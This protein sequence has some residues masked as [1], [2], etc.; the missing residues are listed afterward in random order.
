MR[1]VC[2]KCGAH[3]ELKALVNLDQFTDDDLLEATL[4]VNAKITCGACQTQ[5]KASEFGG[6]QTVR[7]LEFEAQDEMP[8]GTGAPNADD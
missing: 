8:S 4:T 1:Y 5:G 7:F 2:P 6:V 3:E